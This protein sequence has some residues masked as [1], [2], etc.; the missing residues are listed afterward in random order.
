MQS[1]VVFSGM[2]YLD[3]FKAYVSASFACFRRNAAFAAVYPHAL[4]VSESLYFTLISG[5][6][7][8]E[9]CIV[10]TPDTGWILTGHGSCADVHGVVAK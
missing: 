3:G 6:N 10:S 9:H 2:L 1:G 5:M 8:Y 7:W 4:V